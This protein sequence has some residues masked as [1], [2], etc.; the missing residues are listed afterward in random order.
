MEAVLQ[1]MLDEL[2]SRYP[3]TIK[4]PTDSGGYVRVPVQQNAEWYRYL[5]RRNTVSRRRYPKPRTIIRRCH[6]IAALRRMLRG[7]RE[8][9]YAQ[10][11]L[12][13]ME[14]LGLWPAT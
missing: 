6:T 14:W 8:T 5:C 9:V 12:D 4:V 2:E 7:D 11:I 3:E 13:V 10:R 1:Y